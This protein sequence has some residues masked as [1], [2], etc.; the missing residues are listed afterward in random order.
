MSEQKLTPTELPIMGA[1][2]AKV[3]RFGKLSYFQLRDLEKI[4]DAKILDRSELILDIFATRARTH[5]AQ[6]QVGLAQLEYTYPRLRHM[7]SHLERI[8]GGAGAGVGAGDEVYAAAH[9]AYA[10]SA[11]TLEPEKTPSHAHDHS[12]AHDHDHDH[13]HSHSHD[14]TH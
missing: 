3:A 12:D 13:G 7:W 4:I 1:I 10:K 2:I 6:L 11:P 5:E 9:A 8:S 14:H